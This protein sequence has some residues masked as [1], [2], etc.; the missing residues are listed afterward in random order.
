MA[1]GL[2]VVAGGQLF[3]GAQL[4]SQT[5]APMF[6]ETCSLGIGLSAMLVIYMAT[7][8]GHLDHC[9]VAWLGRDRSRKAQGIRPPDG[10]ADWFRPRCAVVH[11]ALRFL[12]STLLESSP[13]RHFG[14]EG[15]A[16][17][18]L[19]CLPRI[20]KRGGAT[21]G[22]AGD[23]P[24]CRSPCKQGLDPNPVNPG[25]RASSRVFLRSTPLARC[26]RA[27]S[28]AG[29]WLGPHPSGLG[30]WAAKPVAPPC[31]FQP[32]QGTPAQCR[33]PWRCPTDHSVAHQPADRSSRR[34][35]PHPVRL[36]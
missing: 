14:F 33:N 10:R 32:P 7:S 1:I 22:S 35:A 23:R 6:G 34:P 16:I 8:L 3:C 24:V 11:C 2:R 19:Y 5:I 25:G 26:K 36:G 9:F 12:P 15:R 13:A 18:L 31:Q 30:W 28:R 29:G 17:T 27:A 20:P 4:Q 21:G